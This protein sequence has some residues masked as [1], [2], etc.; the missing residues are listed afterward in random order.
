MAN[1]TSNTTEEFSLPSNPTKTDLFN[2]GLSIRRAVIGEAYVDRALANGNT[3]FSRTGQEIVTELCWGYTWGRPGLSR[4]DRS[5]LNIGMLMAMN[6]GPELGVHIRGARNNGLSELEIREAIVHATAYCGAPA[7]VDAFKVAERVLNEMA[8]NGEMQ[9][10]L[11]GKC[12][13]N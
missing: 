8:E 2:T 3:Q 1:S 4:R 5:L 9:R 12:T 6:R 11:G 7:G 13:E 10:E